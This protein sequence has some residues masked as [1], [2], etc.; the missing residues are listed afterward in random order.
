M[1]CKECDAN[2][3]DPQTGDNYC[4][5]LGA[6]IFPGKSECPRESAK[7]RFRGHIIERFGRVE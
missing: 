2:K 7:A 6:L 4:R 1:N 3:E 5:M